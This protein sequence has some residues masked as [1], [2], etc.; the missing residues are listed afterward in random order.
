[1]A[2]MKIPEILEAAGVV[3]ML[4]VRKLVVLHEAIREYASR[5]CQ[6]QRQICS[7]HVGYFDKDSILNAPEPNFD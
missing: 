2:E 1:M 5:K 4:S 3:P 7:E 6:E